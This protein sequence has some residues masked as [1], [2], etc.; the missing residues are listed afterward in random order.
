MKIEKEIKRNKIGKASPRNDQVLETAIP[1]QD[2]QIKENKVCGNLKA[3]DTDYNEIEIIFS[4]GKFYSNGRI[5]KN[6]DSFLS[7]GF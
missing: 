3:V 4:D 5:I 7:G 6:I 1:K 2:I